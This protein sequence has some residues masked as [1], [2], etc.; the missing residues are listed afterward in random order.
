MNEPWSWVLFKGA[1]HPWPLKVAQK[2]EQFHLNCER[3]ILILCQWLY[4]FYLFGP[5]RV[6]QGET[7][8]PINKCTACLGLLPNPLEVI[9]LY[10]LGLQ[11]KPNEWEPEWETEKDRRSRPYAIYEPMCDWQVYVFVFLGLINFIQILGDLK[12]S[13]TELRYKFQGSVT[14]STRAPARTELWAQGLSGPSLLKC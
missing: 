4:Y 3:T 2:L 12:M 5:A 14:G 8:C 1:S 9:E 6:Q 7:C 10:E 11:A 13:A